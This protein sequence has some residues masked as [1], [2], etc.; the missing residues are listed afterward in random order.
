[1]DNTDGYFDYDIVNYGKFCKVT[2]LGD[3]DAFEDMTGLD[4]SE[5][6]MEQIIEMNVSGEYT[7]HYQTL[8]I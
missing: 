8:F 2:V 3:V 6:S 4:L 7:C 5:Y 1:M